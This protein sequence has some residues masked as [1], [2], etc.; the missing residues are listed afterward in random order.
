M[1]LGAR[2]SEELLKTDVYLFVWLSS[3]N[4]K[5]LKNE[6]ACYFSHSFLLLVLQDVDFES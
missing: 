1:N 6:L 4:I 2:A 3:P 5:I